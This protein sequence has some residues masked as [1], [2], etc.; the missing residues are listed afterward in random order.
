MKLRHIK[1]ATQRRMF[2]PEARL[3]KAIQRFN[4][5]CADAMV[6]A[7]G[8]M[9]H[10]PARFRQLIDATEEAAL[11]ARKFGEALVSVG[12]PGSSATPDGAH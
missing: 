11:S 12:I 5:E 4:K 7:I 1:R 10:L 2:G 6:A 8:N 9:A 3:A